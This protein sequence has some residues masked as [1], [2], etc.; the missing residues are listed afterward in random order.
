MSHLPFDAVLFD[1]DGVL[2]DS[3]RITHVVL[4][5]MLGEL[6][7]TLD[8]EDAMRIFVGKM[9]K[10]EAARIKAHTGFA[11]D[12]AWLESFRAR[13]NDALARDLVEIPGAPAAVRAVHAAFDGRIA[14]ASGADRRKVELQLRKVGLFEC[15]EAHIYSGHEMPRS[16]PHPDV[17][18]AAAAGLRVAPARCAVIEDTVSGARAGLAAG[19]TVF[20]YSPGAPGHSSADALREAGVAHVFTDMA[21]LPALLARGGAEGAP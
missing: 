8:I 6:G 18:L 1:C 19:A 13:R 14:V 17:Y 5:Q 10:D 20:G 11:I 9:V 2:V 15:F 12:D 7:W 21:E 3:E 16:K 4:V